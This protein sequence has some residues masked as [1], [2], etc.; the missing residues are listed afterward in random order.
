M[1]C[2]I[3]FLKG[4]LAVWLF[5]VSMLLFNGI[6]GVAL[7]EPFPKQVYRSK[8]EQPS[9]NNLFY[10]DNRIIA[11]TNNF[12]F[13]INTKK[14]T[15][16]PIHFVG[17]RSLFA[18]ATAFGKPYAL[19][20]VKGRELELF[21]RLENGKWSR[22]EVP[23]NEDELTENYNVMVGNDNL[24]VLLGEN[25]YKVYDGNN[26]NFRKYHS[27]LRKSSWDSY[28]IWE[29]D[30]YIGMNRGEWGGG[31]FKLNLSSGKWQQ[32]Y[33]ES[34]HGPVTD[35]CLSPDGSLW[36]VC[37]ISHLVIVNGQLS[38]LTREGIKD[39][40]HVSKHEATSANWKHKPTNFTALRFNS[41]GEPVI[42]TPVVGLL[43][44][45]KGN[46]HRLTPDWPMVPYLSSLLIVNDSEYIFGTL[47]KGVV[48]IDLQRKNEHVFRLATSFY[49]WEQIPPG[50]R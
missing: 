50:G 7:A 31:L 45:R 13:E 19:G 41:N 36:I 25:F 26:W 49:D 5:L 33:K 20:G 22:M 12:F 14:Q 18:M 38:Q 46:W 37:G 21:S 10:W 30:V 40:L 9:I 44:Y 17:G 29:N 2:Y 28:I 27:K 32:V 42:L 15:A 11:Q 16:V 34:L 3:S 43:V 6:P 48:Y 35:I 8:Q 1:L 47:G 39:V 4:V 23:K 24:L